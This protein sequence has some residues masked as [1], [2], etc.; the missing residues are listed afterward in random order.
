MHRCDLRTHSLNQVGD[1]MVKTVDSV[2]SC[3]TD[4]LNQFLKYFALNVSMKFSRFVFHTH[5]RG[6]GGSVVSKS[7]LRPAGTLLSQVRA[8]PPAPQPDGGPKSLRSPCCGLATY[9]N[10]PTPTTSYY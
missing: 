7:A 4:S 5:T 8:P 1:R 2:A 10:Q 3:N 9:K 6:V